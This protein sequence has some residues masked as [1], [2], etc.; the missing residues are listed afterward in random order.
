MD[1]SPL[2]DFQIHRMEM[3]GMKIM[4]ILTP[5]ESHS[6]FLVIPRGGPVNQ[7]FG[8]TNLR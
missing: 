6:T 3:Q 5:L 1:V 2:L 7:N 8:M 4:S